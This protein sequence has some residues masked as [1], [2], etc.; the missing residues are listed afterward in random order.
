[1]VC[2]TIRKLQH[3][4]S[5]PIMRTVTV[6]EMRALL[7]RLDEVV[8]R[9]GELVITRHGK[10]V[11]RILP[12][13]PPRRLPSHADH[14]AKMPRLEVGSEVYVRQERDER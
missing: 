10:P 11:A 5:N 14:L 6:R 7:G 9:E 3:K 4:L 1:M 2:G 12:V 8:A 13:R